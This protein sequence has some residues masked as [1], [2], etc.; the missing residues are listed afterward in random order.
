MDV[1]KLKFF[2]IGRIFVRRKSDVLVLNETEMKWK[3]EIEL[4]SVSGRRP[5]VDCRRAN[6]VTLL[7]GVQFT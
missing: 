6:E 3:G 2:R 1:I 5:G 4:E 7:K